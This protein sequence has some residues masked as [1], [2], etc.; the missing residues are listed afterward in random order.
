MVLGLGL[1]TASGMEAVRSL[2]LAVKATS[3]P[4]LML[5][6]PKAEAKLREGATLTQAV[7]AL[8]VLDRT[9]LGTLAIAETTG[10]LDET[11][12]RMSRELQD[13]SLRASRMLIIVV[14]VLVASV[15]LIK[16]VMGLVGVLL[17]PVKTLYDAAG[18]GNLDG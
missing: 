10:T 9:S 6:L 18:S 17:G 3:S 1:A 2:R 11:L 12:E 15:L 8:G 4:A 14:T 16:I 5:E 13:S 7:E